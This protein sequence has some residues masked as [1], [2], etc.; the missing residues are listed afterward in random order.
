ML[1]PCEYITAWVTKYALTRGIF[2]VRGQVYPKR[3][4]LFE[5]KPRKAA[6]SHHLLACAYGTEWHRTEEAALA[7]GNK[8]RELKIAALKRQL[9]ILENMTFTIQDRTDE[10]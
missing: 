1:E 4:K 2:K 10:R 7:R 3:P 6:C 5:Y 9:D 8:L